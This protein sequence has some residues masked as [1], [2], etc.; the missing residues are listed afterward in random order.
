[1]PC[2]ID[3][4]LTCLVYDKPTSLL[5][6]MQIILIL[7][8][9]GGTGKTTTAL[10]LAV[11]AVQDGRTVAVVDLDPQTTATNW[12]DRRAA[13]N[14][15][16]VSCQVARLWFVLEAAAR[17]GADLAIIDTPA[18]SSEASIA[19]ARVADAVLIP[20]RP[21]IYDLETL[22]ALRDIL[23]LAGKP[24]CFVFVN[25][26]PVR[27]QRHSEAQEAA[28]GLGF[29]VC[30]IVLYRREAH[31]DAPT[32]GQTVTEYEP[33]GKAARE[34]EQLYKFTYKFLNK[35]KGDL[36]GKQTR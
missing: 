17:E 12:Q 31:G 1:V 25:S 35:L 15:T 9:K 7:G 23:T 33:D 2:R 27:G 11:A 22:P 34:V 20:V 10:A 36:D 8:Q 32:K 29:T 24:S 18:K 28:K 14:P 4:I 16:V 5:V 30:P 6:H 13:D 26:A 3:I 21:Q 19:A